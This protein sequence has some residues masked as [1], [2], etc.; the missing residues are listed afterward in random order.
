[1]TQIEVGD[2]VIISTRPSAVHWVV[3]QIEDRVDPLG[4]VLR[5]GMSDRI[6]RES[7]ANLVLFRKESGQYV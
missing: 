4:V 3:A 7:Y 5:S 6:R 1:L 2:S